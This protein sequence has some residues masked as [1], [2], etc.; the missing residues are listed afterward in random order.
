[1]CCCLVEIVAI[2][3]LCD[4]PSFLLGFLAWTIVGRKLKTMKSL[5]YTCECMHGDQ[6]AD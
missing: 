2:Q 5:S 6:D 1:M 4:M 3:C